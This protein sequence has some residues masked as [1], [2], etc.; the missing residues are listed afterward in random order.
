MP[1]QNDWY[2]ENIKTESLDSS[3][4]EN[5]QQK[6][7]YICELANSAMNGNKESARKLEHYTDS[8]IKNVANNNG[9]KKS[10][11]LYKLISTQV[12]T[13]ITQKIISMHSMA[14]WI[15]KQAREMAK[16]LSN[17]GAKEITITGNIVFASISVTFDVKSLT[18]N[19]KIAQK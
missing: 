19:S 5:I 8:I 12:K 2:C 17:V 14:D 3:I 11:P 1:D 13:K 18:G 4:D 9:I 6:K 7:T 15:E 10:S 16:A